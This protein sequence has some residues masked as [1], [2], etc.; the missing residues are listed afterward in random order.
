[1]TNQHFLFI[2]LKGLLAAIKDYIRVIDPEAAP[3]PGGEKY[4][5]THTL[6]DMRRIY[7]NSIHIPVPLGQEPKVEEVV[8]SEAKIE[9]GG[10]K[11][12]QSYLQK[13]LDKEKGRKQSRLRVELK[14]PVKRPAAEAAGSPQVAKKKATASTN[15]KKI[16]SKPKKEA[17]E[18]DELFGLMFTESVVQ[19]GF[20]VDKRVENKYNKK[21]ADIATELKFVRPEEESK[22]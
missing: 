20:I 18:I 2:F 11:Y 8:K 3:V 14:T 12:S 6:K 21:R 16:A 19:M 17:Q 10:V 4:F 13:L 9:V 1:M 15:V 22:R 7:D 5:L